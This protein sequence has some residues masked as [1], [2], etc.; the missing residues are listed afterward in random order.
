MSLSVLSVASE[1]V[2]LI[3]TGGLADVVGAL[4]AAVAPHDVQMTTFLPGYPAV[5]MAA[6]K[7]RQVH[8]YDDLFGHSARIVKVVDAKFSM[9]I[10]DC[11][12]LF[13]RDGGPYS[14]PSGTDWDDN[15]R[16][17]AAFARAAA[18]LASGVVKGQ[19][20][21]ILHAHD[22]QSALAPAYLR[23]APGPGLAA[24]AV[25]TIHNIAFQGHYPA[26]IFKELGLPKSAWSVEGVMHH[27]EVSYLKGGME[28]AHAITTVSPS[29]AAEIRSSE[30]GMGLEGIVFARGDDVKGIVNGIDTAVWH[31]S[32][33]KNL[34]ATYTA[35]TLGRRA[36]NKRAIESTFGLD[37]D[38]GPLFII[39]S[40]LAWQKGIDVV[41]EVIDHL[42]GNGCRL[43]VLGSGD[44]EL[45]AG[46][47]EAVTRHP[48]RVGVHIGYDEALSHLMQGG[49]DAILVPSRF[50]PCGLTQLY[51]LAYG[52]VPVVARTG[53]LA[54][55]VIDANVAALADGVATGVQFAPVSYNGLAHAI[56]RT[57]QLYR[58]PET[59]RAIQKRGMKADFSWARSGEAY[60]ELYRKLAG[61]K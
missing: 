6:G 27:D 13:G 40:R 19:H 1:A 38:D 7:V 39:V 15:W 52:C 46:L 58:D 11:P 2:P 9:L 4:P 30:F 42:V 3:K 53:G 14:A 33:D 29:Y 21:E 57:V 60:A 44:A 48:G 41:L 10:L 55:T 36:I 8:C 16:R 43:A 50:E 12:D 28:S 31:P 35:R 59:W 54:D 18:D 20:F 17:F 26:K 61:N 23:F 37:Q 22:W 5:M 45:E 24:K 51:A 56:T 25:M 34:S 49:G 32:N 47:H